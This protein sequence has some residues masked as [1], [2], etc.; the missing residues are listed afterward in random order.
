MDFE[1]ARHNMI[2]QQIRTWEVF[3]QQ[4]L[5]AL[6]ALP[7]EQFIPEK[8]QA[9]ALADTSIPLPHG[10]VTMT[11]KTEA[12]MLQALQLKSTDR[13][14]EIGTGCAYVTAILGKLCREV[15]SLDIHSEFTSTATIQLQKCGLTN[16]RLLTGDGV[17]GHA[18]MAPYDV[19]VVTGSVGTEPVAFRQQLAMNGRLFIIVGQSPVMEAQLITRLDENRCH[20]VTLFETDLPPLLGAKPKPEFR[21]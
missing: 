18:E 14:L 15:V 3:D 17:N 7:R 16:V 6:S 12:R 4:V 19:I 2:D 9:L 5:D 21:L 8:Y 20:K 1:L 13:V 10:Q 11:P